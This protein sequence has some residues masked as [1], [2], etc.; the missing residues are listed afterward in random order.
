[1]VALGNLRDNVKVRA[2]FDL[3]ASG[4]LVLGWTNVMSNAA[5]LHRLLDTGA[6]PDE[7]RDY[8]LGGWA[9][10]LVRR[11]DSKGHTALF[12][13]MSHEQAR[14]QTFEREWFS[15]RAFGTGEKAALWRDAEEKIAAGVT[16][17]EHATDALR[18]F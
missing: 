13:C 2:A 8:F 3:A 7:L 18:F 9:Q 5:S 6:S 1:M 15:Q 16:T 17:R 10:T 4:H 11:A 12:D 14:H